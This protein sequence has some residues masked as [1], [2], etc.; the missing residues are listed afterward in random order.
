MRHGKMYFPIP[1]IHTVAWKQKMGAG[2]KNFYLHYQKLLKMSTLYYKVN[3]MLH[4]HK[5][6]YYTVFGEKR[7]HFGCF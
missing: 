7:D 3:V 5:Q 1:L 4:L 2:N 6:N